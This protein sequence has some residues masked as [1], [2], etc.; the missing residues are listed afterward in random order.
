M[1][2]KMKDLMKKTEGKTHP[3]G[4]L[5]QGWQESPSLSITQR[6]I[7]HTTIKRDVSIDTSRFIV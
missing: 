2:Y 5:Y 4:A 3:K 7:K 1:K 6:M